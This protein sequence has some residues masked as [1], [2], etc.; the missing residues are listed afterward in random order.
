VTTSYGYD[1]AGRLTS[2]AHTTGTPAQDF[3]QTLSF[4]PSGQLLGQGQASSQYVWS[5][6][7]TTTANFTHDQLNRDAAMAAASGY[8]ANGNLISDG[9]RIFTY[10]AENRLTGVTGGAAPVTL[11]YD[12]WGRLT[13][14]TANGATTI[15][16]NIGDRMAGEL[17]QATSGGG[18][19]AS[20]RDYIYGP[21]GEL[22][23]W[24]AGAQTSTG[25]NWFHT[26]RIGS[27]VATS[28][29]T[30]AITP[31]AYGPYG[32]PQS[33]A[34][35]RFRYTGQIAIPEAQL[36]H[37]RA[38]AYDPMMGRFLQSD[39][40]R[41]GAGPN[42]YRYV[43][44]DPVNRRD[45]SGMFDFEDEGFLQDDGSG[46]FT[47]GAPPSDFPNGD[48]G[49]PNPMCSSGY[50]NSACMGTPPQTQPDPGF[51]ELIGGVPGGG[52]SSGDGGGG[53]NNQ[54]QP[55]PQPQPQKPNVTCA[56]NDFAKAG[57]II[58]KTS[59]VVGGL[60]VLGSIVAPEAG[61]PEGAVGGSTI[62]YGIGT[63]LKNGTAIANM[64]LNG[65]NGSSI[66]LGYINDQILSAVP[67][68]PV[69]NA[70]SSLLDWAESKAGLDA[71]DAGKCPG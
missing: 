36:Y 55:Q 19:S 41:Y 68:G 34:G 33:W 50:G 11:A 14:V 58:Q 64:I 10:D 22:L 70:I 40:A 26:D 71:G 13:T 57:D 4:S 67:D 8:D 29:P 53:G 43:H 1:G 49:D 7:P 47:G 6:Q 46:G 45:P 61:L 30:A 32:E 25:L 27:V 59:L 31:Y 62:A 42:L 5:G 24:H 16:T 51:Q 23:A 18:A 44:G 35:S 38:R 37:Y 66:P 3:L 20:L 39:P 15:F 60:G 2:L 56:V 52:G 21:G 28:D 48:Y 12:T 54:P 17:Q 65:G 69:K 9:V 63:E